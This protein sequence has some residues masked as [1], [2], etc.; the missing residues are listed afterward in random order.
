MSCTNCAARDRRK[1]GHHCEWFW[2]RDT[3]KACKWW[4][5]RRLA[6]AVRGVISRLKGEGK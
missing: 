5:S 1:P 2:I 6:E 3:L 4:G